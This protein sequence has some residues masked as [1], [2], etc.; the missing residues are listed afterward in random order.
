MIH[1][2]SVIRGM[3]VAFYSE[4][5]QDILITTGIKITKEDASESGQL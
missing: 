5:T 4:G 1:I 2:D 3:Q